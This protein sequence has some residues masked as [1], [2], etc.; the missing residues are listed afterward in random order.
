MQITK[1]ERIELF[2]TTKTNEQ[3]RMDN[4]TRLV[5]RMLRA[6][7]EQAS[8]F[9]SRLKQ[10]GIAYYDE[11]KNVL[12]YTGWIEN[13][14]WCDHGHAIMHLTQNGNVSV[15]FTLTPLMVR[16]AFRMNNFMELQA[17]VPIAAKMVLPTLHDCTGIV[18]DGKDLSIIYYLD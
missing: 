8:R 11:N 10:P 3:N 18:F 7:Y 14:C 4:N 1:A 5:A 9:T 17:Y 13:H 12:V 6:G 16:R 15:T 2:N